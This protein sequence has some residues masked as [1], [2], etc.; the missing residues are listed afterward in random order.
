MQFKD[1]GEAYLYDLGSTNGTRINKREI[2]AKEYVKVNNSDLFKFGDSTRLYIYSFIEPEKEEEEVIKTEKVASASRK[3]RMLKLYEE[4]KQKEEQ[5]KST[6]QSDK[7]GWG[8]QLETE[9]ATRVDQRKN[10]LIS[11]EDIQR[12]GLTFGQEINYSALKNKSDLNDPQKAV[13]KKAE[14][15][16]RRI[17]KLTTELEGIQSKQAK[18]LDLTEGQQQR[19]HKIESELEE[20]REAIETQEENIRNMICKYPNFNIYRQWNRGRQL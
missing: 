11:D 15:T 5:L 14:Q 18:M 2:P 9:D 10:A 4:N 17:E 20:L 3:E 12:F 16:L 8:M 1:T 7:I 6:T 13:I 19:Y